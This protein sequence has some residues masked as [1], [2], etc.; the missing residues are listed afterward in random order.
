MKVSRFSIVTTTL[1]I[2]TLLI[3][4]SACDRTKIVDEEVITTVELHDHEGG[5]EYQWEDLEGDGNPKVDTVRVKKGEITE[6][7]LHFYD[8]STGTQKEITAEIRTLGAEHLVVYATPSSAIKLT[9][10]DKDANGKPLGLTTL[11]DVTASGQTTMRV[12]LK[13]MPNKSATDPSATGDTDIDV[14]FPVIMLP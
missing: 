8:K 11:W 5:K 14:T 7:E 13:H 1:L 6:F 3:C 4:F 12:T 2:L 10:E 9:I